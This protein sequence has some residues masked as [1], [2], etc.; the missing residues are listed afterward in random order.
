MYRYLII[1]FCLVFQFSAF[2]GVEREIVVLSSINNPESQPFWRSKNYEIEE[3][4]RVRF[5]KFFNN[6]G[7]KLRFIP[8]ANAEI[9]EDHLTSPKTLALYWV[10]HSAGGEGILSNVVLDAFGNNVQDVFKRV[11]P[12]MV[13]LGIIGCESSATIESIKEEGHWR[14][15]KG[16]T[17]FALDKKIGLTRG[18]REAVI[19]SAAVID[20]HPHTFLTSNSKL[21]SYRA[22]SHIR[23]NIQSIPELVK[24]NYVNENRSEGIKVIIKNTNPNYSAIMTVGNYFIGVLKRTNGPQ[25]FIIPFESLRHNRYKLQVNFENAI[26]NLKE[27]INELSIE[28][29]NLQVDARKN[30]SGEMFGDKTNFYILQP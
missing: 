3:S 15:N 1:L 17:S 8:Q 5:E 18:I 14:N 10:S 30:R 24:L 26:L 27:P 16:L 9:L 29:F 20:S 2:S 13:F 21:H 25:E 12:N 7:Y 11:N 22:N 28:V 6:S 19:A 4:I 23:T